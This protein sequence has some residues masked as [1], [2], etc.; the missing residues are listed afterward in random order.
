[1][2]PLAKLTKNRAKGAKRDN[3]QFVILE[4]L[5]LQTTNLVL[6][7][8]PRKIISKLSMSCSQFKFAN[9]K[10]SIFQISS[11]YMKTPTLFGLALLCVLA[12]YASPR[13][14]SNS[15]VDRH[16]ILLLRDNKSIESAVL[17]W[18][19]PMGRSPFGELEIE[20]LKFENSTERLNE[21]YRKASELGIRPTTVTLAVA[22]DR[23]PFRSFG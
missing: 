17:T 7:H 19:W 10:Y 9:F 16:D 20:D 22:S 8:H 11:S 23:L 12:A 6:M 18:P 4:F 21:R 14:D 3:S 15:I 13:I 5:N 2:S 1:M